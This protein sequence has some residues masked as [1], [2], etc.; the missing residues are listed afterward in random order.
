MLFKVLVIVH[1]ITHRIWLN[2]CCRIDNLN[3]WR[4]K[5][6]E[7][8]QCIHCAW[9]IGVILIKLIELWTDFE[10]SK[11]VNTDYCITEENDENKKPNVRS[12]GK[13]RN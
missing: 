13:N 3:H 9:K 10:I 1:F 8:Y 4:L 12:L 7:F 2:N 11:K 5:G 6:G